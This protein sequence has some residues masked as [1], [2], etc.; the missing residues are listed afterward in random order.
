MGGFI[1]RRGTQMMR[2]T[3]F[4]HVPKLGCRIICILKRRSLMVLRNPYWY[5]L[6]NKVAH[7]K[8]LAVI[9]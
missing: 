7:I 8:K 1:S 6:R 5:D 2:L 9:L 4:F 3:G